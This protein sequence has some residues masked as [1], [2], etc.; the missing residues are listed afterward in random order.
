MPAFEVRACVLTSAN[1]VQLFYAIMLLV[2]LTFGIIKISPIWFYKR[3]FPSETTDLVSSRKC[4]SSQ[5]VY[6]LS[7]AFSGVT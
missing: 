2:Y 6:P 5:L 1:R 3:I 4:R 7:A